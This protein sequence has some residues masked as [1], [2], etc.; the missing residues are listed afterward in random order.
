MVDI[1]ILLSSCLLLLYW[2]YGV[3]CLK[4]A[5]SASGTFMNLIIIQQVNLILSYNCE[6]CIYNMFSVGIGSPYHKWCDFDFSDGLVSTKVPS[7]C[8]K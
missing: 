8:I 2:V 5:V 3:A 1:T 4:S 6:R 7:T